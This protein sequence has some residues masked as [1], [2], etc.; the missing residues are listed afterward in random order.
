MKKFVC[1]F[2]SFIIMFNLCSCSTVIEN[3][4]EKSDSPKINHDYLK[5]V[6]LPYYEIGEIFSS[7]NET[8]ATQ[9]LD[10]MFKELSDM[11][12]NT[13]FFHTRAFC[14]ALYTS[15]LFPASIY[16]P[17]SCDLLKIAVK[18]AHKYKLSIHA[19]VNPYRVALG[20]NLSELDD[21]SPAKSLYLKDKSN[22][23]IIKKDI[24][25]NPASTAAQRLILD[26]IREI[27]ENYDVDGVHFDDYFYP[28]ASASVDKSLYAKYK[29]SS[30]KLSLG[31][32]R[33]ESV[34]TLISAT[35][36]VL[37]MENKNLIFGVSPQGSVETNKEKLFADVLCWINNSF[38]D[39]ICPQIYFGFE[40]ESAPFEETAG[41]W[42]EYCENKSVKL[43]CG[44]ALY[45][46]GKTDEYASADK[47]DKTSPYY[48]WKNNTDIISKQINTINKLSYNGFAIYSYKS[49]LSDENENIIA[50]NENLR[51][52][53]KMPM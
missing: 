48:E 14:D 41:Q 23:I 49:L 25:L 20:K 38:V 28:S 35:K 3:S 33:I 12:F 8:Q 37:K 43:Y 4:A 5:G 36:L 47:S 2:L 16:A 13:V 39:Y 17:A 7:L 40:N 45:K 15:S 31:E 34:N 46:S 11:G 9:K 51:T 24:Y 21:S 29:N 44:L 50:E 30:G 10:E 42:K 22:L 1:L 27:I 26:G 52:I 32:W 18:Q 19:W 6:W 53:L